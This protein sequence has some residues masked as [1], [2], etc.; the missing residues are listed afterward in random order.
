[1]LGDRGRKPLVTFARSATCDSDSPIWVGAD[2]L[3]GCSEWL[4]GA[5]K[6]RGGE[7]R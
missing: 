4:C 6:V 2:P 1:M 5:V 3:G 7:R